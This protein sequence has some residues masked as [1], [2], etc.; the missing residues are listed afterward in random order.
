MKRRLR[1]LRRRVNQNNRRQRRLSE[2]NSNVSESNGSRIDSLENAD[3]IH[4]IVVGAGPSGAY[5]ARRLR[6]RFPGRRILVLEK[7]DRVGGRLLSGYEVS[8]QKGSS[9]VYDELGG[10]RIFVGLMKNVVD[11]VQDTECTLTH[12]PL[13]VTAENLFYYKGQRHVKS[14][15]MVNDKRVTNLVGNLIERF[16]SVTGHQ[17]DFHLSEIVRDLSSRD[18]MSQFGAT[19][20]EIDALLAYGGYDDIDELYHAAVFLDDEE[21]Y[22]GG[23]LSQQHHFVAEG[24]STVIKRLVSR[25][26]VELKLDTMVTGMSKT[27]DGQIEVSYMNHGVVSTCAAPMVFLCVAGEAIGQ[28]MPSFVSPARKSILGSLECVPLFKCFL[29]W[30]DPLE[31]S[32]QW[33]HELG[34]SRGKHTT[35]LPLR[36]VW[37]YDL[38]DL[39]VY[40][41]GHTARTWH[42]EIERDGIR[43]VAEKMVGMLEEM[44]G[45]TVP[46][47]NYDKTLYHYWPDGASAWLPG[48]HVPE[49]IDVL[50][51][52]KA[53]G[54]N[55]YVCGDTNSRLQ[56]WV[57]GAFDSVDCAFAAAGLD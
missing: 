43:S 12:V 28:L 42:E 26:N 19:N 15:F 41:S 22:T 4:A 38:N 46:P 30:D 32:K 39:L 51:N 9:P 44:F 45:V 3:Q 21:F 47:P 55:L 6:Q 13:D 1:R 57:K 50:C 20:E 10:M 23:S 2:R 34:F 11:A 8:N 18:F 37:N 24:Y 40:N 49:A 14:D 48:Q 17:G 36:M 35:D 56:G 33:W 29:H 7:T 53:D 27:D 25:S 16:R 54:S 52:G 31:G 5:A